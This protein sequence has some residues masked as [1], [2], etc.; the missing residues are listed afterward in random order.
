VYDNFRA[1]KITRLKK[2]GTPRKDT[3]RPISASY[4]R[5]TLINARSMFTWIIDE[6]RWLR[7]NPFAKVKGLGKRKSG[8]RTLTCNELRQWF[9]T[10]GRAWWQATARPSP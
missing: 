2:D 10:R 7:D 5:A 6:K 4:H 9:D 8:K 3:G 1:R